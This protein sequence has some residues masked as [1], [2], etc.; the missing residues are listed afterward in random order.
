MGHSEI[1]NPAMVVFLNEISY[2]LLILVPSVTGR[3]SKII[4][5]R[6]TKRQIEIFEFHARN[7]SVRAQSCLSA[8]APDYQSV[9]SYQL[10]LVEDTQNARNSSSKGCCVRFGI[11]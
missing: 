5:E 9:F 3:A 10:Y 4:V 8:G 2:M 11:F 6:R 1:P 7:D